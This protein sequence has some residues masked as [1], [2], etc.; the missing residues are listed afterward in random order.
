MKLEHLWV[1]DFKNL[2]ECEIEFAQPTLLSAVIGGNGSG[3]SNLVEAI[4]HILIVL[5]LEFSW[6]LDCERVLA[7]GV[8]DEEAG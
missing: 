4:L 3:K 8:R 2:R 1:D 6:T 7:G 5:R